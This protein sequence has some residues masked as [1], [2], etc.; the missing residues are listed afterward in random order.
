MSN[1]GEFFCGFGQTHIKNFPPKQNLMMNNASE[2]KPWANSQQT[3]KCKSI[4]S[5]L[6]DNE[7]DQ[8]ST[9][10]CVCHN[11]DVIEALEHDG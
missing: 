2:W 3:H 5:V 11:V 9:G 10:E 6:F 1:I 8:S 7:F 4:L